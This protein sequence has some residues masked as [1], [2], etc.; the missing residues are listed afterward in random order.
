[1]LAEAQIQIA[2]HRVR[3]RDV[4]EGHHHQAQEEHG[5]NGADPVPVR[6]QNAVL[7]SRARPAHQL[8]RAEVGGDEAQAGDPGGHLAP[9][10]EELFAGVGAALEIEADPDHHPEVDGDH[11]DVEGA[12]MRQWERA[13]G[14]HHGRMG[15][16]RRQETKLGSIRTSS[17]REA[18]EPSPNSELECVNFRP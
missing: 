8:Q 15:R 16:I 12:Q 5:R 1:M 6:G 2:G 9:G 18:K 11:G 7:I 3:L 13:E 14:Q 10:H 4:V 17:H